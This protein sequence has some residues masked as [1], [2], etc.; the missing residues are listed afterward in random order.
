MSRLSLDAL[1]IVIIIFAD[2]SGMQI[3]ARLLID[4]PA[5]GA[6]LSKG[7]LFVGE[8]QYLIDLVR[9]N[10]D[11]SDPQT[12]AAKHRDVDTQDTPGFGIYRFA[13]A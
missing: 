7:S 11:Q 8:A 13:Y 2:D 5:A 4:V 3:D 1:D 9:Q 10:P 6:K 12:G